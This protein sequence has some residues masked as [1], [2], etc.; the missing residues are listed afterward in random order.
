[1]HEDYHKPTDEVNKIDFE[2]LSGVTRLVM[3]TSWHITN[4]E[5]RIEVDKPVKLVR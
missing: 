1:M 4:A 3:A 5:K 2:I